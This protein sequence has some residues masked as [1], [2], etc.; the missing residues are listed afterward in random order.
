M[1]TSPSTT[2]KKTQRKKEAVSIKQVIGT[3]YPNCRKKIYSREEFKKS[4]FLSISTL[5]VY[6]FFAEK[7]FTT[8]T[9]IVRISQHTTFSS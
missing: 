2:V 6:L 4:L 1:L 3:R 8:V 7:N 9:K 5:I